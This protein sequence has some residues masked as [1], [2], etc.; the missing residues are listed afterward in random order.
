MHHTSIIE[1]TALIRATESESCISIG[2]G[3]I[4]EDGVVIETLEPKFRI[5]IGQG[6]IFQVGCV[7]HCGNV[8]NGCIFGVKCQIS[9]NV[10][11]E[12]NCWIG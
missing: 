8:G 2:S 1:S 4:V 11:V 5:D 10:I 3:N 12:D 6:N 9:K 7:I